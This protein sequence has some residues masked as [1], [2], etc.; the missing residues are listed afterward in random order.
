MFFSFVPPSAFHYLVSSC[1]PLFNL[2][3]TTHLFCLSHQSIWSTSTLINWCI[4]TWLFSPI[5]AGL[6][7]IPGGTSSFR[8]SKQLFFCL[9]GFSCVLEI[10]EKNFG[11][12]YCCSN[13]P[14]ISFQCPAILSPWQPVTPSLLSQSQHF[15]P[16][17]SPSA[18]DLLCYSTDIFFFLARKAFPSSFCVFPNSGEADWMYCQIL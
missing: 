10:W 6:L 2:L 4:K 17:Q 5:F 9:L 14:L 18:L 16:F 11:F 12:L 1:W 3:V 7:L 8:M 13:L 15:F